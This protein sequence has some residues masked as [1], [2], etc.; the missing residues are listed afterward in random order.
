MRQTV[1]LLCA[2]LNGGYML[3]DGF[4]ASATGNYIG[5]TLGPWAAL[6]RLAGIDPRSYAMHGIFIVYGIAWFAAIAFYLARRRAAIAAMALFT[7]WYVPL[8]TALSLIV[9]FVYRRPLRR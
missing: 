2:A 5:G 7:L 9:L 4:Y 3:L 8:G 6:V 1:V